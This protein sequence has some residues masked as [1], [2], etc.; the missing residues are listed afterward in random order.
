MTYRATILAVT[1]AL[2]S[3][4]IVTAHAFEITSS[5][6]TDGG[7]LQKAQVGIGAECAGGNV[8]PALAWKDPPPGTR[9]FALTMFDPDA[10]GGVWHWG[11]FGIAADVEALAGNAGSSDATLPKGAHHALNTRRMAA[12]FGACPPA[13]P[14]HHYIV[15]LYALKTAKPAGFKAAAGAAALGRL[16]SAEAVGKATITGLYGK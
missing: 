9:S 3:P 5:D 16:V 11:V 14:P 6:F 15:T 12:Y 8:S 7:R 1:V 10:H 2:S 4:A 13:G